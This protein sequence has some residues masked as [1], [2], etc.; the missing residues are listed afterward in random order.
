MKPATV[1][2]TDQRTH[3]HTHSAHVIESTTTKHQVRIVGCYD[4]DNGTFKCNEQQA[5]RED[6]YTFS[7]L[8]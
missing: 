7:V 1:T 8:C 2:N 4:V 6:L 5:Q 3:T